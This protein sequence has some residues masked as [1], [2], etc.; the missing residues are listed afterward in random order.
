MVANAARGQQQSRNKNLVFSRILARPYSVPSPSSFAVFFLCIFRF[1]PFRYCRLLVPRAS[2]ST[3]NHA[4]DGAG[5]SLVVQERGN[6]QC[7]GEV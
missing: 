6:F 4:A 5:S 7:K 2:N 1:L 3:I